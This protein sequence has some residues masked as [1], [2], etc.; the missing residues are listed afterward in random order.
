MNLDHPV[1]PSAVEHVGAISTR[2]SGGFSASPFAANDGSGGFNLASHVGDDALTVARNRAALGGVVP[3]EPRWL[4]QVHGTAVFHARADTFALTPPTADA[5]IATEP[6]VVCAILTA[7]CLPVL[8]CDPAGSVV[9]AAHAGWRGL[10][11]GVLPKTVAAMR[12]AGA[13]E[14]CAWLGPAIGPKKFE[15]GEDVWTAFCAIDRAAATAFVP[16]PNQPG[17]Y[18]A[19]LYALAR[20]ALAQ[21]GVSAISGGDQCTVSQPQDYFSFRRDQQCGRMASLIWIR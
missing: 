16:V 10:A 2:R 9:G 4:N 18:L 15:V 7:D 3:A 17:K 5:C 21:V 12:A 20:Q 11:G 6:G 1:W 13:N 14:L 19:D 8:L